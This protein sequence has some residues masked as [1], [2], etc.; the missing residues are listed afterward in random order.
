MTILLLEVVLM[1]FLLL[2]ILHKPSHLLPYF[3]N[4]RFFI[5]IVVHMA[6]FVLIEV[7][8]IKKFMLNSAC[9]VNRYIGQKLKRFFKRNYFIQT[10]TINS[11][12]LKMFL[13]NMQKIVDQKMVFLLQQLNKFRKNFQIFPLLN[14]LIKP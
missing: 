8:M 9:L 4:M 5:R 10:P 13:K 6:I 1:V 7:L 14:L 11:L 3:N 2:F 12:N